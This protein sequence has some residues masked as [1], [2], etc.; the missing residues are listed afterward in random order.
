[1]ATDYSKKKVAEL[2]DLLKTRNLPHTGKKDDLISRLQENDASKESQSTVKPS[3]DKS[4]EIDDVDWTADAAA[5]STEAGS[6]AI[7]AGG[8]GQVPN[9]TAVPNQATATDPSK[10]TDLKVDPPKADSEDKKEE[11]SKPATDFTSG[12]Q[13]TSVDDEIAKRQKRAQRFGIQEEAKSEDAQKAL[14]RAKKFGTETQT[15]EVKGLDQALPERSRKRGR[16]GDEGRRG[17]GKRSRG[18]AGGGGGGGGG[19]K[20]N[21]MSEKDR[22]ASEARKKKFGLAS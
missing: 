8:K 20:A 22:L 11:P 18:G 12:L 7:A 6:T 16:G 13:E 15:Q 2:Q 10:T 9:P 5:A 17:G 1:M 21:W 19:E 14:D 4:D 3:P